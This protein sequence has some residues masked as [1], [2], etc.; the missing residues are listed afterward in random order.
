MLATSSGAQRYFAGFEASALGR[1][2]AGGIVA[3]GTAGASRAASTAAG[4]PSYRPSVRHFN[5][6][7]CQVITSRSDL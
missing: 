5:G 6:S 7:S 3:P 4:K 2:S 1:A